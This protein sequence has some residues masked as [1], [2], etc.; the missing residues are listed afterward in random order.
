MPP[1][2]YDLKGISLWGWATVRP[3]LVSCWIC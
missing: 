3:P 1:K 2:E